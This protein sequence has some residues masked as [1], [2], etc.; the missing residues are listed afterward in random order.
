VSFG[1]AHPKAEFASLSY[2]GMVGAWDLEP[3]TSAVSIGDLPC[4]SFISYLT[5]LAIKTDKRMETR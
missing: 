1:R 4:A 3:Q 5:T 2:R